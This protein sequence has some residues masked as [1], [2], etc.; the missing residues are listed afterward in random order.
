MRLD[1]G[2][3]LGPYE[4]SGPI[5]AGGMGEV[6]RAR[7]TRLGREVAIKVL[8]HALTRDPERLARFE[9]EAHSASALNHPNIVTI[10][11]FGGQ[12]EET[13]LVMELIRG[14][15][16]RNVLSRGPLPFKKLIAIAAGIADGLAAAHAAGIVHRDLKPENVMV[17]NEGTAKILDFGLVKQTALT[18]ATDSPTDMQVSRSGK[19]LGTAAY[20]SPEQARGGELDFRT[21]QF[22]LGLILHEM[23]TGKHPFLRSTPIET[24]AAILNDEPAPLPDDC[25]EPFMWIV[26]RCLAKNPA[27]RYGSTA[28]LAY[29]LR[30]VRDRGARGVTS[31]R[32]KARVRWWPLVVG[33][34]AI[35]IAIGIATLRRPSRSGDPILAAVATPEIA[36]V[37]RDEV[38]LPVGLSPDG[39]FLV[40]Y[41]M[42]ADGVPGL[43]LHDLRSDTV[44]QIAQNAFSVGWSDDSKA[45]AFFADR[46]LKTLPVEGGP[47]R[48]VCDA[49]PEGT[50]SWRGDTILFT[51]YS[52]AE[53][54][55]FRVQA[56]GGKPERIVGPTK[57]RHGLPWWPELLPDGK[58]FLYLALQMPVDKPEI[59]HELYI[60]SLDGTAPKKVPARID[61]RAVYADGNLLYVRDGAL[62]AQPFDVDKVKFIGD[63]TTLVEGL[64]YFHNT[65]LAAFSISQNGVLAWRLAHGNSR[66]ALVDRAGTEL[67]VIGTRPF[68]PDGRLSPDG[69][70]YAISIDDPKQGDADVWIFDLDRDSSE[71]VTFTTLDEKAPVW[72]PDG[73][74]L[75]YRSD[76]GGGPP[77]IFRLR[78]GEER[79]APF[80]RGPGV[81]EPRDVSP[82]GKFLLFIDYRQSASSDIKLLT[83]ADPP[84]AS[85][86]VVTQFN[87]TSPRF[88][89]DGKHVA[90]QSDVSGRPDVY[91]RAFQGSSVSTRVSKDG[92]TRPRWS[93]DGKE[94]F[95]LAPGGRLMSASMNP[96]AGVPRLLFTAADAVDF[97]PGPDGSRFI[98]QLEE[99]RADPPI[100]LLINWPARLAHR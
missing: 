52:N 100:H 42:D 56:A 68:N 33:A 47:P 98:M 37:F 79:G 49:L 80:Y 72:A 92:G 99:R 83:L 81:E 28:D 34:L 13:W 9:R 85:A 2:S 16:L 25:P 31:P 39:H 57:N 21:D 14:E 71:R 5:G 29:E 19:I 44:R 11:D 69:H 20:M 48:I 40:V 74:T 30:R 6:Y 61:S 3:R 65:G 35:A 10:H 63:A 43:W 4:I 58:H 86:F 97:E 18:D 54:G 26:E 70:R 87:E 7:D 41:G 67:K 38:A 8:P 93:R 78:P 45:I 95:F 17:T 94:L 77:D 96:V 59:D 89:P 73:R 1:S 32:E 50:P 51:Q 82:D 27:E 76:G 66:L 75:Y 46:K 23:A 12:G 62:I 90:Y 84:A 64:H 91:V 88:S 36:R 53:P 24:L 15:S 22:S 60:G 55:I